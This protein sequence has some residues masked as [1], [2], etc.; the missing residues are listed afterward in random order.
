MARYD[1]DPD[2]PDQVPGFPARTS[3]NYMAPPGSDGGQ[4]GREAS[5]AA[6]AD[7]AVSIPGFTS[8][9]TIPRVSVDVGDSQVPGQNP[10]VEPFTGVSNLS[11]ETFPGTGT[12][13]SHISTPPHPNSGGLNRV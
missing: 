6:L 9:G 13:D 8:Q 4:V 3:H 1:Q 10:L 12:P 11:T 7:V 2:Y 5:L